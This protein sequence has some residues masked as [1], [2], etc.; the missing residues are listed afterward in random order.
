MLLLGYELQS[1]KTPLSESRIVSDIPIG[2]HGIFA[3]ACG[4]L[5]L[6]TQEGRGRQ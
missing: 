1:P 2:E 4:Y 5:A 6:V 3:S